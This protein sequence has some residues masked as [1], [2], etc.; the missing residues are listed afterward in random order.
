MDPLRLITK[1]EKVLV[2]QT[3]S[4]QLAKG[5]K[6]LVEF[7]KFDA[8]SIAKHEYKLGLLDKL[9]ILKRYFRNPDGS[10]LLR[11]FYLNGIEISETE[12]KNLGKQEEIQA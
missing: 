9:Y 12:Y 10:F 2:I 3:R 6:S 11:R 5:A 7:D 1:Y 8:L 4:T